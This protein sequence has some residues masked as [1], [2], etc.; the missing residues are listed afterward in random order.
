MFHPSDKFLPSE[1]VHLFFL[2]VPSSNYHGDPSKS[3]QGFTLCFQ[4][5][6]LF[7]ILLLPEFSME[8]LHGGSSRI[9]FI[10]QLFFK[11]SFEVQIRQA[12]LSN[13]N[14]A[15]CMSCF[16]EFK[17]SLSCILKCNS[18][19]LIFWG[20]VMSFLI[21]SLR[22]SWFTSFQEWHI[23]IHHFSLRSRLLLNQ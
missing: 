5:L 8:A 13:K 22:V 2:G 12:I 1:F 18:F 15:Q 7:V 10:V 11:I 3:L 20:G 16:E 23:Y 6:F 17:H 19:Y 14:G 21:I 9:L 4:L